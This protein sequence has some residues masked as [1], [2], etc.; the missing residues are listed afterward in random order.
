MTGRCSGKLARI[1]TRRQKAAEAAAEATPPVT[2]LVDELF[3]AV[4]IASNE[5]DTELQDAPVGPVVPVLPAVTAAEVAVA[6]SVGPQKVSTSKP[7]RKRNRNKNTHGSRVPDP[8]QNLQFWT[9]DHLRECQRRDVD[10]SPAVGWI[11]AGALPAWSVVKGT[12]PFTR[13]LYRQFESLIMFDGIVYRTFVGSDGKPLRYQLVM[14]GCLK[15]QFLAAV[16]ADAAAHLKFDKCVPLVQ[17]RAWWHTYRTDLEMF[18]QC[19]DK[20]SAFSHRKNL[21]HQANLR[22][23]VIGAPCERYSIDLCGPFVMSNGY[24][25][26]FTAVDVF[27]RFLVAVPLRDKTAECVARALFEHVILEHGIPF[28]ILSDR[29]GEFLAD[30]TQELMLILGIHSIKTTSYSPATNGICERTHRTLNSMFA[31]CVSDSQRDWSYYV[32]YI[33][34]SYNNTVCRST[35]FTPFM[36]QTGRMANWRVDVLLGDANRGDLNVGEYTREVVARTQYVQQLVREELDAT[37][38]VM[39]EWYNKAVRVASFEVGDRVRV[40]NPRRFPQRSPKWQLFY[41][42]VATVEEKVNESLYL[43]KFDRNGKRAAVHVDKLKL[44]REQLA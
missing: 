6:P 10:I 40:F 25:Y 38:K 8:P 39:S 13:A 22:P 23:T 41:S 44:F 33:C 16:H 14:P 28:E 26:V 11:E 43:V 37:N 24:H 35:G 36:V 5:D 18:I 32:K 27:S 31:K 29:G 9:S 15:N 12:S 1:Q 21:Q 4:L 7:A 17:D 3:E 42:T 20:C 19:C 2:S 30:V 34:F